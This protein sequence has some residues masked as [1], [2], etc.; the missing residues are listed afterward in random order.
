MRAL[1]DTNILLDFFP[2]REPW[3]A[4]AVALWTANEQGTFA[5]YVCATTLTNVFYIVRKPLGSAQRAW[6]V[7]GAILAAMAV[8]P[9]DEAILRSAHR[10]DFTDYEVDL[11]T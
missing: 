9:V 5:G 3:D 10:A 6:S 11:A 2:Q 4:D 7:V 1:L 8:C